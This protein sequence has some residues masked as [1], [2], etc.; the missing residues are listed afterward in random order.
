[1]NTKY[2]KKHELIDGKFYACDARNF[3]LGKWN[4][5]LN[6]FTYVRHKMG[7]LF[8][9]IEYHYDDGAHAYGTVKPLWEFTG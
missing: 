8:V 5:H 1:M 2:L 9:D 4:E 7:Q 6:G 3:K